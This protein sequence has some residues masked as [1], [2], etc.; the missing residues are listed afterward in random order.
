MLNTHDHFCRCFSYYPLDMPLVNVWIIIIFTSN[1]LF[2]SLFFL[3]SSLFS[4]FCFLIWSILK[5]IT[6]TIKLQLDKY[7]YR[8]LHHSIHEVGI[9]ARNISSWRPNMVST[10]FF[11]QHIDPYVIYN[12]TLTFLLL[13][14]LLY[15][16]KWDH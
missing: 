9:K 6:L 10:Q 7:R 12:M 3:S 1:F 4:F 16:S 15:I 13:L 5:Q 8:Y 11:T 14:L 2:L